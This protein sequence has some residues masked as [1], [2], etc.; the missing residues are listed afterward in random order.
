M[1]HI[2]YKLDRFFCHK[3]LISITWIGFLRV[4]IIIKNHIIDMIRRFYF[5]YI[6]SL[7]RTMDNDQSRIFHNRIECLYTIVLLDIYIL[8][9]LFCFKQSYYIFIQFILVFIPVNSHRTFI[10]NSSIISILWNIIEISD[11]LISLI[12]L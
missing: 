10:I 2:I 1:I 7:I 4:I 3:M 5:L 6:L 8:I 11:N 9:S 12:S